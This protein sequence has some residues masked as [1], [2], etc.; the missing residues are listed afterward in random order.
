M[1]RAVL[2]AY[3]WTDIPTKYEF[4]LDYEEEED[5]EEGGRKQK[6]PWRYRWPDEIRDEILARLLALNEERAKEEREA[7]AINRSASLPKRRG[8]GR[9][10]K[11][12]KTLS[13]LNKEK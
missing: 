7:E 11:D 6:K 3:G 8:R 13:L 12:N 2:Y 9:K 4:L 1:D 5:K 10:T